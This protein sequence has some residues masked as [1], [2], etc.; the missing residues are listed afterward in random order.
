V[1]DSVRRALRSLGVPSKAASARVRAAWAAIADPEW[2]GRAEPQSLT[3]GV[4]VV[5]VA[6]ASLRHDLAQYHAARLLDSL[7]ATLPA[8]GIAALR[9]EPAENLG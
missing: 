2:A 6:S 3:G 7:R 5:G 9:F 8:E 4:L 1:G